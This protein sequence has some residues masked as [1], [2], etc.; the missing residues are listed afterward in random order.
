MKAEKSTS[1]ETLQQQLLDAQAT[2]ARQNAELDELRAELDEHRKR[3]LPVVNQEARAVSAQPELL[4]VREVAPTPGARMFALGRG[5]V[6]VP[7]VWTKAAAEF[8]GAW[9]PYPK[10]PPSVREWLAT[11]WINPQYKQ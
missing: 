11:S 2:I 3:A 10:I 7:I 1:S 8:Y 5:G 9:M 4:D 6:L